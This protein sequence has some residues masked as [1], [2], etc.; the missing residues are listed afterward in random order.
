MGRARERERG[1]ECHRRKGAGERE[2]VGSVLCWMLTPV[3]AHAVV[4][5]KSRLRSSCCWPCVSA[6]ML[7]PPSGTQNLTNYVGRLERDLTHLPPLEETERDTERESGDC[8]HLH[9]ANNRSG[10]IEWRLSLVIYKHRKLDKLHKSQNQQRANS[11]AL[12][13]GHCLNSGSRGKGKG[14]VSFFC[15]CQKA[16]KIKISV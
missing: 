4:G 10:Q 12:R 11:L 13:S 3:R 5:L 14:P 1:R 9:R 8:W 16:V 7:Q 2:S 6:T 15:C